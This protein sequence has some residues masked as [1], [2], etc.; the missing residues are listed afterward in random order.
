MSK[1]ATDDVTNHI[2]KESTFLRNL[3]LTLNAEFYIGT[4]TEA[5]SM[6]IKSKDVRQVRTVQA[7]CKTRSQVTSV[8]K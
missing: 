1:K 4:P 7:Q 3:N 8:V 6:T 5:Q 2:D